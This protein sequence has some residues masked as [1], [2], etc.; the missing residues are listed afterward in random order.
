MISRVAF[1]LPRYNAKQPL[2]VF[3]IVRTENVKVY[4]CWVACPVINERLSAGKAHAL[5]RGEQAARHTH[6]APGL[7][8]L[9]CLLYLL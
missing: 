3:H 2:A 7:S 4:F 6:S 1:S 8:F 5:L 9:S